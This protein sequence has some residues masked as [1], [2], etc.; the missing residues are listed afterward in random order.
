VG[1]N[2][3]PYTSSKNGDTVFIE[4][5]SPYRYEPIASKYEERSA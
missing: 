5:T 1:P 4:D 3:I 2:R